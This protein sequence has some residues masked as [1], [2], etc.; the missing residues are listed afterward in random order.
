M[1]YKTPTRHRK[2]AFEAQRGQCCYCGMPMWLRDIAEFADTHKLSF[3]QAQLLKC[4]AEHL[5][6]R[7]S[8]GGDSAGNIA[9]AC[10]YC[11]TR[12]HKRK[13]QLSA[14]EYRQHVIRQM[15]RGRWHRLH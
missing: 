8:G 9:A 6:A 2:S 7:Q 14:E 5:H 13:N 11:N 10:W 15:S 4:T 3:A 12:R 1:P